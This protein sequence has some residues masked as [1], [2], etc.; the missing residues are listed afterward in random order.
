MATPVD[1]KV[2]SSPVHESYAQS[3]MHI[4]GNHIESGEKIEIIQTLETHEHLKVRDTAHISSIG[5]L[6]IF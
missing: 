2:S 5:N 1:K 6:L 3:G 4:K